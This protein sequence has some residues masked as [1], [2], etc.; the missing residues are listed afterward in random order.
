MEL[1]REQWRSMLYTTEDFIPGLQCHSATD[2]MARFLVRSCKN[3]CSGLTPAQQRHQRLFIELY[4]D[5]NR[6][7]LQKQLQ[8]MMS[9]LDKIFFFGTLTRYRTPVRVLG[10]QETLDLA[11]ATDTEPRPLAGLYNPSE[12]ISLY[13]RQGST[14]F[15]MTWD[16]LIAV[17]IHEM[18]H[19]LLDLT[20]DA[21]PEVTPHA[22]FKADDGHG[23]V[24]VRINVEVIATVQQWIPE[25]PL[26][27]AKGRDAYAS[28]IR[29]GALVLAGAKVSPLKDFVNPI[30]LTYMEFFTRAYLESIDYKAGWVKTQLYSRWLGI[31]KM[32]SSLK[33][34]DERLNHK[35]GYWTPPEA[36]D[37]ISDNLRIPHEEWTDEEDDD[38]ADD[39]ND[40]DSD[41][42][43]A[44]NPRVM[45]CYW[46]KRLWVLDQW[47]R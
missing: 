40:S 20:C 6:Y 33:L 44:P 14:G 32:L 1:S 38:D 4:R 45:G 22:D 2:I 5:P 18:V 28:T 7:P 21:D 11:R 36:D 29:T 30:T 16:F 23:T 25:I 13:S 46:H 8:R 34:P 35:L 19:G 15:P 17:L 39:D 42:E 41:E 43:W 3:W 37:L 9:C 24:W 47:R 31:E 27:P 12:G 10:A 26:V